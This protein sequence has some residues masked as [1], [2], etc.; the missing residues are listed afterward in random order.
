[1]NIHSGGRNPFLTF[2]PPPTPTVSDKLSIL[3]TDLS[4]RFESMIPVGIGAYGEVYKATYKQ[5]Y[6][7][8]GVHM[9][10]Q[11]VAVKTV[12]A[13]NQDNEDDEEEESNHHH[14][15]Y[16]DGYGGGHES[17]HDSNLS[18]GHNGIGT[19]TVKPWLG[20]VSESTV[21]EIA[22]LKYLRHD[23]VIR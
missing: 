3:K 20:G 15:Q 23:H 22:I 16:H 17:K 14:H 19:G 5:G 6:E 12:N 1:M 10:G 13:P 8:N 7:L 11:I 4:S 9:G 21:R 2:T 18:L